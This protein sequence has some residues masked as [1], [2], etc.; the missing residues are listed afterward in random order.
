[1]NAPDARGIGCPAAAERLVHLRQVHPVD[2]LHREV[3]GAVD[4]AKVEDLRDVAVRERRHDA[5]LIGEQA[6][7]LGLGGEDRQHALER[8]RLLEPLGP[9]HDGPVHLGHAADGDPVE[10]QVLAERFR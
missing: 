10:E 2:E 9:S 3:P 1:M 8:D 5:R 7:E 6:H 4:L